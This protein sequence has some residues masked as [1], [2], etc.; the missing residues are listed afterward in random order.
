MQ[1]K[2]GS[3]H[4]SAGANDIIETM[5]VKYPKLK[6]IL[7]D[8]G[9]KGQKLMDAV[10]DKLDAELNVVLRPGESS[11]KFSARRYDGLSNALLLGSKTSDASQWTMSS[12]HIQQ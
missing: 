6:K 9:Y 2:L 7:A 11:K 5:R 12:I 4:D 10:K 1:K 8:G 3:P